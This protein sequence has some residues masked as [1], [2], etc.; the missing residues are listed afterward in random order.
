MSYFRAPGIIVTSILERKTKNEERKTKKSV[1]NAL[2]FVLYISEFSTS[3]LTPNASRLLTKR[4]IP[5]WT[6]ESRLIEAFAISSSGMGMMVSGQRRL[7]QHQGGVDKYF[8]YLGGNVFSSVDIS[9]FR[10][11][12]SCYSLS[13]IKIP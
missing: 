3:R 6:P 7:H 10:S 11:H 4:L 5:E 8:R 12:L 9:F 2:F 1:S 13:K